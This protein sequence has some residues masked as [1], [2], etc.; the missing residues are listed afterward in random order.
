M[1]K[2]VQEESLFIYSY[3]WIS[4]CLNWNILHKPV[5]AHA[6]LKGFAVLVFVIITIIII[7]PVGLLLP[8]SRSEK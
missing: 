2:T 5:T 7:F 3:C 4:D 1:C 8:N 6:H